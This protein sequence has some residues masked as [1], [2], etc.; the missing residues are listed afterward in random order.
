[1]R[2]LSLL[3]LWFAMLFPLSMAKA[4]DLLMYSNK[5]CHICQKFIEQ[6]ADT[7]SYSYGPDK[8]LPLTIIEHNE[9]PFW[10][11]MAKNENRIK[12]I[13]GTPTF[14]IWNGRKEVAR[15]VG[16]SSKESFYSRLD[17]MFKK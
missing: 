14:I 10:F 7:Y 5:H 3:T 16:Y 17:T 11:T 9:E 2:M 13:R 6:V 1:M 15:L 8:V 4:L 12:G